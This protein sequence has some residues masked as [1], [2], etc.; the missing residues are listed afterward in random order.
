MGKHTAFSISTQVLIVKRQRGPVCAEF[1]PVRLS[2]KLSN[3]IR[4]PIL[5]AYW[6]H[7]LPWCLSLLDRL[8][9]FL[10]CYSRHI[11]LNSCNEFEQAQYGRCHAFRAAVRSGTSHRC[12]P[13]SAVATG[14]DDPAPLLQVPYENYR[15]VFRTSQKNIEKELGA[16]QN[17]A[18]DLAKKDSSESD[19][20]AT[21]KAIDSM[22]ARVEGLKRKV[23]SRPLHSSF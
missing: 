23:R 13:C 16:V 3:M 19:A 12:L 6:Q 5:C 14:A 1:Y 20:D 15:K 4:Y 17:A 9:L 8:S 7:A 18:N 11:G 10:V 21:L 2:E 22:I